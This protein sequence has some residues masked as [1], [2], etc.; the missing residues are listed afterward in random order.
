MRISVGTARGSAQ[1]P[2]V[3]PASCH[4][5]LRA[6]GG[7]PVAL[8]KAGREFG[9]P[10]SPRNQERFPVVVQFETTKVSERTS[11]YFPPAFTEFRRQKFEQLSEIFPCVI[12]RNV[13]FLHQHET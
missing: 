1:G 6:R 3:A 7:N 5:W 13:I 9:G 2:A 8:A 12:L 11:P 10:V 4:A